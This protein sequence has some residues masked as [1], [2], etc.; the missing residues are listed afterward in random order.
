MLISAKR[1]TAYLCGYVRQKKSI[2]ITTYNKIKMCCSYWFLFV[3]SLLLFTNYVYSNFSISLNSIAKPI[4]FERYNSFFF[5]E[6]RILLLLVLKLGI[7]HQKVTHLYNQDHLKQHQ[8]LSN[9][10]I[11]IFMDLTMDRAQVGFKIL[12]DNIVIQKLTLV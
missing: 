4:H 10:K 6:R 5:A 9:P 7:I 12:K 3:F 8:I 2:L 11:I 1:L